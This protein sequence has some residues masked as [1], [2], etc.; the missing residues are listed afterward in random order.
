M[1]MGAI[2]GDEHGARQRIYGT[3]THGQRLRASG[4]SS[5]VGHFSY[6]VLCGFFGDM[7]P[8]WE[9]VAR[10]LYAY[11]RVEGMLVDTVVAMTH[12]GAVDNS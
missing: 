6:L 4:R 1:A 5:I 7:N 9:A 3:C 12:D 2:I 10:D 8:A 11:E